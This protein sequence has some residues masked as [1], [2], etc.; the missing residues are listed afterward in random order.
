MS[1]ED[2]YDVLIVGAGPAG[3][4]AGIYCARKMLRTLVVSKDVGGQAA[5]SWEVENYL[6]Y[7]LVSGAELVSRFYEHLQAFQVE[8]REREEVKEIAGGD[9]A[10]RVG[11]D[12]GSTYQASSL[13][14]ASGKVP[15]PLNVPGEREFRGRGVVY[16][17]TCDAPLFARKEVAVIG[18]GNS[19]LDAALQL[20]KIASRVY[21]LTIEERLTGDPITQEQLSGAENVE[22]HLKHR[23]VE[24]KGETF[25]KSMVVEDLATG[26][27]REI[28][29]QGV[30]IEIGTIPS[31]G[32]LRGVVELNQAGE[33]IIDSNNRTSAP[34][35]FAAG[36]VT[37]V[38]EKQI[39]IAAGE[40]AKAALSCY[41]WLVSNKKI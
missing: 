16:C 32:F 8:L 25:V 23:V 20:S 29:L 26:D 2:I 11:T 13:I 37:N 28:P 38:T 36:D 19:G 39:I 22:V 24:I 40:G 41:A 27:T 30:F 1:G 12:Q 3:L 35:I 15:R 17:A 34:G 21:L 9:G 7:Q 14:I 18:G 33:V 4:A 6:G 31:S 10:F 5:W